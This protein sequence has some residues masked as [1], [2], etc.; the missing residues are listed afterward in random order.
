M[1]LKYRFLC[2]WIVV[3]YLFKIHVILLHYNEP[4]RKIMKCNEMH[5]YPS[6]MRYAFIIG[7]MS[8]LLYVKMV[9]VTVHALNT[10]P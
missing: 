5:I 7:A 10:L 2:I 3:K 6:L 9:C 4:K 1:Y 8:L